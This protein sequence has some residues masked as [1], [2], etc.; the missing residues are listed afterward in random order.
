LREIKGNYSYICIKTSLLLKFL[1]LMQHSHHSK[2]FILICLCLSMAFG[3]TAGNWQW[4]NPK[5]QGSDLLCMCRA[6]GT[7]TIYAGGTHSILLRSDDSGSTWTRI[8]VNSNEDITHIQFISGSIGYILI[9]RSQIM[10]TTNAGQ[11]WKYCTP[12]YGISSFSFINE[13]SGVVV[14]PGGFI[15]MTTDSCK[16]WRK[17][18]TG[19]TTDLYA[20]Q[21]L[22]DTTYCLTGK[23]GLFMK[24]TDSCKSWYT[25]N[26]SWED[27]TAVGLHFLS[28]D[29]GC[30]WGWTGMVMTYDGG[31]NWT[32]TGGYG[33]FMMNDVAFYDGYHAYAVGSSSNT[34]GSESPSLAYMS[35]GLKFTIQYTQQYMNAVVTVGL[36][37][38]VAVGPD[39]TI[40]K[41]KD[42]GKTWQ[43]VYNYVTHQD[44][45]GICFSSPNVGWAVGDSGTLLKTTDGGLNWNLAKSPTG[46]QLTDVFFLNKDTGW[47]IGG[48]YVFKT[49]DGAS[50]WSSVS[51][52][53]D[54]VTIS[55]V[56]DTL[57]FI[58]T[59]DGVYRTT[60]AKNWS[61]INFNYGVVISKIYF[62]NVNQGWAGGWGGGYDGFFK[63]TD[64]GKTWS[65]IGYSYYF[66]L[67]SMQFT[68]TLNGWGSMQDGTLIRTTN[69]GKSW[70]SAPYTLN[71]GYN[72]I[73]GLYI[74]GGD[75]AIAMESDGTG[76]MTT[77][78]GKNLIYQYPNI[79]KTMRK[80][81]Y[82]NGKLWLVG[83]RGAILSYDFGKNLAAMPVPYAGSDK[84][85]CEGDSFYLGKD[86]IAGHSYQWVSVP[87][88]FHSTLSKPEINASKNTKYFLTET[89]RASGQTKTD[90]VT[91]TV[92]PSPLGDYQATVKNCG[93]VYFAAS[94]AGNT[95]VTVTGY[96]WAGQGS[97]ASNPLGFTGS[98][99]SYQYNK[100][101][102]YYKY[103]LTV[104][105]SN[106]CSHIYN[107]SVQIK[108]LA[109]I[110][111]PKDTS[112]CPS[113]SLIINATAS[114]AASPYTITWSTGATGSSITQEIL[115]DTFFAAYI[116]DAN[117]CTNYDSMVVKTNVVPIAQPGQ[118][119]TVCKGMSDSIG[120]K[121][122]SGIIYQWSS[123]PAG[124]SS[125]VSNPKVSPDTTTTYKLV[126][127]NIYG[128]KGMDSVII[129][130]NQLP[131]ARVISNTAICSGAK[132]SIGGAPVSG[133][134]Y[135]WVSSP[136]G[137]SSKLANPY[138]S[139][140]SATSYTLTETDS[141]GCVRSNTVTV[142]V[143]AL[144]AAAV[145]SNTAICPGKSITI[146]GATV[147]GSSYSWTGSSAGFTS[148][149]ANPSVSPA[150]TSSYTLTETNVNGCIKSD[151]LTIIVNSLPVPMVVT[152]TTICPGAAV[153]IGSPAIPGNTYSWASSPSGFSSTSADPGVNPLS[154]T[155]YMLT[156]TITSTGCSATD[157][158]RINVSPLPDASWTVTNTSDKYYFHV[159][160]SSW[161]K[162]SYTWN[163]GD[164]TGIQSGYSV[165]HIFS[166]SNTYKIKLSVFNSL[167]C[168]NNL[169]S[170][171]IIAEAGMKAINN[172]DL[173]SLNIYPNPFTDKTLINFTLTESSHVKISV[174]DIKGKILFIPADKAFGPG[175]NE[176]EI[177]AIEAGLSPGTY[178]VNVIINDQFISKKIIEVR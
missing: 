116:K 35:N 76:I 6:P 57:G 81:Y 155:I 170:T 136:S 25:Y 173:Y 8:P 135:S 99:G 168:V 55:F 174:M 108:P 86:S 144:P 62:K 111:L 16:T 147:P 132:I 51:S 44:L 66:G 109:Q 166:H 90:S 69:G 156:E 137:F 64:T 39:G 63:A 161:S 138:V 143:N 113:S 128:C 72:N 50:T 92:I 13:K 115:R 124:F 48:G 52:V 89:I 30:Y 75:T 67:L 133:S 98:T 175:K 148:T 43:K 151:S 117:G 139:P 178:F 7:A 82:Y 71:N 29:T 125:T 162:T 153:S 126:E 74:V 140:A 110:S 119:Q 77:D 36:N 134:A 123:S 118:A 97:P 121:S 18:S 22:N 85:V 164:G 65:Y 104:K 149:L 33:F 68:D 95:P 172:P 2:V 84:T 26:G 45:H 103:N 11:T 56:N 54:A 60:D 160:D 105:G 5:P 122:L 73:L 91:I 40:M 9:G 21:M 10:K 176:I 78:T 165:N 167:G 32:G 12:Y 53:G 163:F 112:V 129:N 130:V 79:G 58:G 100:G 171:V 24:T 41:S 87:S 34:S 150:S 145:I 127:T 49:M 120:A 27:N 80:M 37:T 159:K 23:G 88:G 177:N 4:L 83:S 107:D 141:N 61:Y 1:S 152:D 93:V 17:K 15:A 28:A 70:Q 42:Y 19:V 106:G 157:S 94:P 38:V 146:G 131:V 14:G 101:G 31:K 158:A 169:D 114:Y 102:V 59:N 154:S 96:T 3:A 142:K 46:A 20:I 47:I